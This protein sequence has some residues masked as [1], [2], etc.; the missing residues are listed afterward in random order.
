MK[1]YHNLVA[2]NL[3]LNLTRRDPAPAALTARAVPPTLIRG[4]AQATRPVVCGGS[5]LG[6]RGQGLG[7]R[8]HPQH[9]TGE[10]D[11]IKRVVFSQASMTGS[12]LSLYLEETKVN[13]DSMFPSGISPIKSED[14]PESTTPLAGAR[15]SPPQWKREPCD[16]LLTTTLALHKVLLFRNLVQTRGNGCVCPNRAIKKITLSCRKETELR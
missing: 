4:S 11:L 6:L 16:V 7:V 3:L 10:H 9:S 5:G 12:A 15:D 2:P 8:G 1:L 14:G 13:E